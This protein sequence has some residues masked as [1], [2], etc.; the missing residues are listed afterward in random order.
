MKIVNQTINIETKEEF[1]IIDV[2]EKIKSII[3]ESE[4]QNGLVN[5]QNLHTTATFLLNEKESLLLKDIRNHLEKLSPKGLDYNHD[6]FTRRTIN[7]CDD[8]C[9]N[10]Y[11]HCRA[12]HFP[13]NICLNIVSGQLQLG[14]W[15]R[16]MFI[17]LDRGRKRN[18]Q[19]QI[20]GE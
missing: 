20:M 15:Q 5:L 9:A 10:G 2:T 3:K 14:Q 13:V 17:E 12:I 8:E 6:D 19:V 18:F 4:I 1:H 11:A 16:I 7:I